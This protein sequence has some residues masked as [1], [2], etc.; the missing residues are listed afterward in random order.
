MAAGHLYTV[1][2]RTAQRTLLP[3]ALLLLGA[4]LLR[5]SPSY[6]HCVESHSLATAIAYLLISRSLPSNGTACHNILPDVNFFLKIETNEHCCGLGLRSCNYLT[7]QAIGYVCYMYV[8]MR[9]RHHPAPTP[10]SSPVYWASPLISPLSIQHFEWNAGLHIWGRH[11]WHSVPRRTGAGDEILN[12]LYP[13][14]HIESVWLIHHLLRTFHKWDHSSIPNLKRCPF[15][16]QC[17]VNSSL[18]CP[19]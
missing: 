5:P 6:G 9:G 11:K 4:C 8:C 19:S 7:Y 13:H 2:A 18:Y 10:R 17:P 1:S 14:N 15:R 16:W 3:I 12:E